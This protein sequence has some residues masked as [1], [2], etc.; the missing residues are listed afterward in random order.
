MAAGPIVIA[1]GSLLIAGHFY[2]ELKLHNAALLLAAMVL[3]IGWMPLP[4]K[5]LPNWQAAVRSALCLA[6]LGIAVTMAGI[7]F[8]E[9]QVEAQSNPYQTSKENWRLP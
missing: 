6:I 2:A 8:A 1:F 3:A 4:A 9:S 7:D 5:L